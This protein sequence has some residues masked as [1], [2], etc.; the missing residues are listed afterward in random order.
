M[1]DGVGALAWDGKNL[2]AGGGFTT[3]GVCPANYI[4][5]WDGTTWSSLET[6]M[7]DFVAA[8]AW[9]RTNLYAGG[10]FTTAGG[11]SANRI[12]KWGRK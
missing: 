3:A 7:N 10:N 2:Y 6:G 11:I 12:A 5:K 4:A 8:L 1:N 9:D